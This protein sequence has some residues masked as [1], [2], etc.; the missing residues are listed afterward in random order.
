MLRPYRHWDEVVSQAQRIVC[1][2]FVRVVDVSNSLSVILSL[3]V[4]S[5]F[6]WM[7]VMPLVRQVKSSV[8][9]PL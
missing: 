7:H 5:T 4:L 8:F 2:A 6:L 3:M 9:A 1:Q